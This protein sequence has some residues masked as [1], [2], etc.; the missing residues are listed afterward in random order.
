MQWKRLYDNGATQ[1]PPIAIGIAA[2]LSYLA[3][4][5]DS[6][7]RFGLA[8][9]RQLYIAS[10]ILTMGIVPWTLIVMAGTNGALHQKAAKVMSLKKGSAEW[11]ASDEE[12]VAAL[13]STWNLLNGLRSLLPLLGLVAGGFAVMA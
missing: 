6:A 2:A 3:W 5:A 7:I 4:N 12:E 11:D 1:N 8:S 10:V 9:Q 13:L